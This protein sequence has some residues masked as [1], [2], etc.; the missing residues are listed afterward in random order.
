M[1]KKYFIKPGIIYNNW[2]KEGQKV[3]DK[4]VGWKIFRE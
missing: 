4:T 2:L 3:D 1:L